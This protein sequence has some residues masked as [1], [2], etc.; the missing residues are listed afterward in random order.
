MTELKIVGWTHFDCEYPT[1]KLKGEDF[2]AVYELIQEELARNQYVFSGQEHQCEPTGVPVFSD[3]TCFRASMRSWGKL[4]ASIYSGPNGEELSYM[5]FYTSLGEDSVM[6]EYSDINV[7]PAILDDESIGCITKEDKQ[8]VEESLS[9]GMT[10]LTT[11]KVLEKLAEK[12]KE[13]K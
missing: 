4:M 2:I 8:I 3:G 11:D 6:P 10:F 1:R 12:M 5:D 7:E 9:L 13:E